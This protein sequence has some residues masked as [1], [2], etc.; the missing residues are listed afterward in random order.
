MIVIEIFERG[1]PRPRAA[2]DESAMTT[3]RASSLC[4]PAEGSDRRRPDENMRLRPIACLAPSAAPKSPALHRPHRNA[5]GHPLSV[6][7]RLPIRQA[8]RCDQSDPAGTV[9]SP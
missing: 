4:I 9:K 8:H 5:H 3:N 7:L 6:E 1:G 2:M